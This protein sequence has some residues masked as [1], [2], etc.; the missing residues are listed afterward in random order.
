MEDQFWELARCVQPAPEL[1]DMKMLPPLTA[2]A[3]LVPSADDAIAAQAPLKPLDFQLWPM[4]VERFP[5]R[6]NWPAFCAMIHPA[7]PIPA[8][9][10]VSPTLGAAGSVT[11]TGVV[12]FRQM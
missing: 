7:A 3:S 9:L 4:L 2:A 6:M 1:V 11:V 12:S 10:N 5:A 8:T